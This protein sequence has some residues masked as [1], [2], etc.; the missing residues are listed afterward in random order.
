VSSRSLRV[1][2][3]GGSGYVGGLLLPRLAE[4][5]QLRVLDPRRPVAGEHLAGDA[6]DRR[7]L[8]EAMGGMDTVIHGAMSVI[9]ENDPRT[10]N[11]AF[12][13]NVTSVYQTL[14][15]AHRAGIRHAVHLSSLSVYRD[16]NERR[17]DDAMP[18]DAVDLY[19]L[20]KRFG[21]EVCR[22]AAAEHGMSINSLRLAWPT[23]DEAWPAWAGEE[24]HDHWFAP[25]GTPIQAT[26]ASDL[27]RAVL[28][29][30]DYRNGFQIFTISGDRS[31]RLWSIERARTLLGWTPTFGA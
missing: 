22:A 30:L 18:P 21:E 11:R 8:D 13:V 9:D 4:R 3:V 28:A 17:L 23:S 25:D 6:C 20:T 14:A 5:H 26:A 2:F 31:A 27:A 12:D 19:G 7:T 15:A 29:A 10:A 24:P 16:V 1:L